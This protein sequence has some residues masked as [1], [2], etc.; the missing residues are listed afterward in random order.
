MGK[1][2]NPGRDA[3]RKQGKE[4]GERGYEPVGWKWQMELIFIL[5]EIIFIFVILPFDYT[6]VTGDQLLY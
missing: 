5:R 4:D 1:R 6:S 3:G 2:G